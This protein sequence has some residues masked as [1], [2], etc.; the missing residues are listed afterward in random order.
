MVRHCCVWHCH[1]VSHVRHGNNDFIRLGHGLWKLILGFDITATLFSPQD[2][3][4]MVPP[5]PYAFWH[6]GPF[7]VSGDSVVVRVLVFQLQRFWVWTPMSCCLHSVLDKQRCP[8]SHLP[9]LYL[10]LTD[11]YNNST[12]SGFGYRRLLIVSKC[13]FPAFACLDV[14]LFC[15][16]LQHLPAWG[17]TLILSFYCTLCPT[18]MTPRCNEQTTNYILT[19]IDGEL[20]Q[21]VCILET[22]SLFIYF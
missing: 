21:H 6:K 1:S 9:H 4:L 5:P 8:S 22:T 10:L 20:T 12:V 13:Y 17:V 11:M 7:A 19:T 16:V 18:M 3:A 14:S 2:T 15:L